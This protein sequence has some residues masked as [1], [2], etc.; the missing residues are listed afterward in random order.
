[1]NLLERLLFGEA[2]T[3]PQAVA[4]QLPLARVQQ[5]E[6]AAKALRGD[7][8]AEPVR[9]VK[10]EIE[11]WLRTKQNQAAIGAVTSHRVK[12]LRVHMPQVE[13]IFGGDTD[14]ATI[15]V[16]KLEQAYNFCLSKIADRSSGPGS[17]HE[18]GWSRSYADNLFADLRVWVRWL[19]EKGV[20]ELPKNLDS[21]RFSF[22]ARTKNIQTWTVEEVREAVAAAQ[23]KLHVAL[24]LQLN[25]GMTQKDAAGLLDSEVDWKLGRIRRKRSKTKDRDGTPTVEYPLWPETLA[26]LRECRGPGKDRVLSAADGRPLVDHRLSEGRVKVYDWFQAPFRRLQA[27]LGFRKPM[28]LLRKTAASLLESHPIYGRLTGLFLGHAP[29]TMKEKHYAAAPQALF[30]EAVTWLGRQ[31]GFGEPVQDTAGEGG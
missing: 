14:P 24:L 26:M 22:G 2:P 7:K 25:C 31:L 17:G 10:S 11:A 5:V 21:R 30:D 16:E 19:W 23:G 3:L 1:M 8:H 12:V 9:T 4:N 13:V 15:D 27:K 6:D 18:G 29:A 20:I 28:K